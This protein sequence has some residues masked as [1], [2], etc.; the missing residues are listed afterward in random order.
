MSTDDEFLS[1]RDKPEDFLMNRVRVSLGH[2]ARSGYDLYI[3]Q[4][5]THI[6]GK[7]IEWVPLYLPAQVA[8]ELRRQ[9]T[10]LL[11]SNN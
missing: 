6:E 2:D 9:L 5:H 1:G 11:P 3:I 10:D 4:F 7:E 8:L